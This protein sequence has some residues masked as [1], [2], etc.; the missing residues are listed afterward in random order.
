[1]LYRG[2]DEDLVPIGTAF[3]ISESLLLTACHNVIVQDERSV[4]TELKVTP[5]LVKS[6]AGKV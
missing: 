6:S 2:D 1:M 4:V 3:A 5:K